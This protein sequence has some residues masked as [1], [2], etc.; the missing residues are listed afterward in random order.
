MYHVVL[1]RTLLSVFC[2][3]LLCS[4]PSRGFAGDWFQVDFPFVLANPLRLDKGQWARFSVKAGDY[5]T[6]L[7]RAGDD[8]LFRSSALLSNAFITVPSW[9]VQPYVGGGVGLSVTNLTHED[10]AR[11]PLL[12][13]SLIWQV[14]GALAYHVRQRFS[15]V[16]SIHF[17]RFQESDVLGIEQVES[18]GI[19][20]ARSGLDT[21]VYTMMLGLRLQF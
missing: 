18:V 12:E 10:T 8:H 11:P 6:V 3:M 1:L 13:E 16:S 5:R 20:I 4:G 9:L 14:G 2:L 21:N 19:A 15:L 7:D 17:V